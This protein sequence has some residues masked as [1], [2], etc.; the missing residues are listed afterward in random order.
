MKR[1]IIHLLALITSVLTGWFL[2]DFLTV[3]PLKMTLYAAFTLIGIVVL[4]GL[5]Y[6]LKKKR[7][8]WVAILVSLIG[9]IGGYSINTKKFLAREDPRFV[10]ELS[11]HAGD[12]G[13]SQV[14]E[15]A[16]S[17]LSDGHIHHRTL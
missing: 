6:A 4:I 13:N 8:R 2:I 12:E 9:F 1:P 3:H 14:N 15:D 10:P 17:D 11:R 5:I 16:F 7:C